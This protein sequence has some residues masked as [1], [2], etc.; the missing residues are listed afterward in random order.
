MKISGGIVTYNNADTI[1]AC[2][3]SVLLHTKDCDFTLY[4]ADNNSADGTADLIKEKF[5]QVRVLS[6]AENKGFGAGHNRILREVRSDYHVVINPDIQL[7]ENT[8]LTLASYLEADTDHTIGQ[9]TPRVLNTDDTEQFLPKYCPSIRYCYVS[10]LPGFHYLRDRYTRK[11]ESFDEP[12]EIE[13][14][15]GCFFMARTAFLKKLGGFNKQFFLYC[16]DSDLSKRV[17]EQGKKIIFYPHCSVYHD[18]HRANT[19][20]LRGILQFTKSLLVYFKRWGFH[21]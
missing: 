3:A 8:I 16:E 12:T 2:I 13:F 5:P 18:W 6:L 17:M 1:E 20:S 14:C 11:A 9:I 7:K 15:T 21:W 4:V 10:K 19:R